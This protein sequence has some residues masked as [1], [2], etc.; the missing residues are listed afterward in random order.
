MVQLI[1]YSGKEQRDKTKYTVSSIN[2]PR[3]LDEFD[4]NIIDLSDPQMWKCDSDVTSVCNA[5]KDL[6]S[7]KTMIINSKQTNIIIAIPQN[8]RFKYKMVGGQYRL[9]RELKDMIGGTK[10]I[11]E[12]LYN[13]FLGINLNYENT[14]T[15]LCGEKIPAAFYINGRQGITY[16][17]ASNK[18]TTIKLEKIIV[19]TLYLSDEKAIEALLKK[20]G[21]AEAKEPIPEWF[22]QIEAFDDME[23]KNIISENEVIIEKANEIIN[24]A[25]GRLSENNRYKSILYT[26][27]DELVEVVFDI[28]Q[29]MLGCDLSDFVDEKKADFIFELG[30][31][32]YIGEIKGVNHNVK[33]ENVSQLDVH[34][35]GYLDDH[36]EVEEKDIVSLLIMNHQKNKNPKDREKIHDTQ[37]RL[38]ERNGSVIVETPVLLKLYEKYKN[39]EMTRESILEELER[40][41]LLEL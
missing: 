20:L 9:A 15:T 40:T 33:S 17:D 16:S 41:G 35:Q 29:D 12:E 18:A 24:E 25:A 19:T 32:I 3:S 7:L 21:F 31:K 30:S 26:T 13:G 28:L 14:T 38:A 22:S 10:N 1:T 2:S 34:K 6:C 27:G 4:V 5:N 37:I 39:G 8:S 11:L 23:Q 36:P